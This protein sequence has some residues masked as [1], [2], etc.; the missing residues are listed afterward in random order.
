ML[1]AVHL[2]GY[3]VLSLTCSQVEGI[4]GTY[5]A[6]R[7]APGSSY[8]ATVISFD[9]GGEWTLITPPAEDY[10]NNPVLCDPVSPYP[11]SDSSVSLLTFQLVSIFNPFG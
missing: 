4:V 2:W 7:K 11:L 5:V 10:Q 6:N 3:A 9:K 8:G 1:L